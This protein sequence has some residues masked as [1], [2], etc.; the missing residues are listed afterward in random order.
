MLKSSRKIRF[1]SY[2]LPLAIF[3]LSAGL[4]MLPAYDPSLAWVPL[5]VMLAGGC[6]YVA[7][8]RGARGVR[9]SAH[10]QR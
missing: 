8:S 2:D 9:I 7:L 1:T 3:L 10:S 4:G 5:A 6:L